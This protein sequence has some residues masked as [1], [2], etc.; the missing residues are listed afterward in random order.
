M[1]NLVKPTMIENLANIGAETL[2]K[3]YHMVPA[4]DAPMTEKDAPGFG[5]GVRNLARYIRRANIQAVKLNTKR[6]KRRRNHKVKYKVD[7]SIYL[8]SSR[9]K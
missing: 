9:T 7:A 2:E 8:H 1:T 6:T 5:A 4:Y 3:K